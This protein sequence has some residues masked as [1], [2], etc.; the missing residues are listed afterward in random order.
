MCAAF[1]ISHENHIREERKKKKTVCAMR[2]TEIPI[3]STAANSKINQ[4]KFSF[5][6]RCIQLVFHFHLVAIIVLC[7]FQKAIY[8]WINRTI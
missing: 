1:R 4:S 5:P 3:N 8:F 7:F 2:S 6:I